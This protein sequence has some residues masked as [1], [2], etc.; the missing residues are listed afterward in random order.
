MTAHSF[1]KEF[2]PTAILLPN[3]L[4]IRNENINFA[5]DLSRGAH[6]CGLR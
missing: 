4:V 5:P 1:Y 3:N 6:N 2:V